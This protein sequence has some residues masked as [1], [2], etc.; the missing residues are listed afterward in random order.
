VSNKLFS[1]FHSLAFITILLLAISVSVQAGEFKNLPSIKNFG[2]INDNYYRGAQPQNQD[3]AD[4][5]ALGIRTVINLTSD[6][7]EANEKMMV[8]NAGMKYYQIPMN[9]HVPPTTAQLTEFLEIVNDSASQP[10]YVHCVGGRHRTGVMTAVYRMMNGWDAGRAYKE[11]K[12]Y[13]FGPGFLHSEFK[14]FVFDYY[15]EV[16]VA[17]SAPSPAVVTAKTAGN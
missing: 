10:V 14:N 11:M 13:D 16:I 17:K 1:R 9:T 4:L 7:A 2:H 12:Q 6:D 3:Y 5:A 8:E 15:D